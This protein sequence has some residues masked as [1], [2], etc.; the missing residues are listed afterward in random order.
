MIWR[1]WKY[2]FGLTASGI[3]IIGNYMLRRPKYSKIEVVVPKE[4]E[5]EE[6]A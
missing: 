3:V 5:E 1:N 2:R 4:E 6:E